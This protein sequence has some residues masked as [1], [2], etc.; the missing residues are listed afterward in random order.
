VLLLPEL[1][2]DLAQLQAGPLE[3]AQVLA[4]LD[5][6]TARVAGA[7][8]VTRIGLLVA[9]SALWLLLLVLCGRPY[10]RLSPARRARIAAAMSRSS[11]P[12]VRDYVRAIRSLVLTYVYERKAA[13]QPGRLPT[14]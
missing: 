2:R 4:T 13:S 6:V 5:F 1:C 7:G 8:E 3:E 14:A 12:G 10:S 11:L 9:D